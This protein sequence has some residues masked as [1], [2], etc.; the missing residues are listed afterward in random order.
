[1]CGTARC[2]PIPINAT[3]AAFD[4]VYRSLGTTRF[5]GKPKSVVNLFRGHT[6]D[7]S[8]RSPTVAA[9][10]CFSL[11]NLYDHMLRTAK[12]RVFVRVQSNNFPKLVGAPSNGRPSR[13]RQIGTVCGFVRVGA[14]LPALGHP[15]SCRPRRTDRVVGRGPGAATHRPRRKCGI[16]QHRPAWPRIFPY[17]LA[18]VEGTAVLTI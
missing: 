6:G 9:F 10:P 5:R 15:S 2:P 18:C 3:Y 8:T 7:I 17:R 13:N 14:D 4:R 11:A 1:M 16:S 12:D